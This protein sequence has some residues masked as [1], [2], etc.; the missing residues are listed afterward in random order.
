MTV[1]SSGVPTGLPL[2]GVQTFCIDDRSSPRCSHAL[3]NEA[4]R[5]LVPIN[6]LHVQLMR[7]MR[8]ELIFAPAVKST[9]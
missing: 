7:Y 3:H 4:N 9:R 8:A 5:Q 2:Y 1:A 6:M